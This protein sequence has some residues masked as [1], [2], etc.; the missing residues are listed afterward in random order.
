MPPDPLYEL[1]GVTAPYT[2][3]PMDKFDVD[4]MDFKVSGPGE[5]VVPDRPAVWAPLEPQLDHGDAHNFETGCWIL[6]ERLRRKEETE[7]DL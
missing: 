2:T 4:L 6:Q 7:F 1:G 3:A 5:V